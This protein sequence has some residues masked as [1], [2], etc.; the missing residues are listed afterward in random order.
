[1]K[2]FLFFWR[3]KDSED[4]DLRV[5]SKI[6]AVDFKSGEELLD[7]FYGDHTTDLALNLETW[8]NEKNSSD[9]E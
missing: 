7:I 8:E 9:Q 5:I 6:D 3:T 1:M 2:K 4:R